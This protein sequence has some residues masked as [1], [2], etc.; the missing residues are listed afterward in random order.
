MTNAPP[1]I[2]R[3]YQPTDFNAVLAVIQAASQADGLPQRHTS[4][5]LRARVRLASSDPRLDPADDMWVASVRAAGVVAYA[6]GSLTGRDGQR[7]YRSECFV[8]PDYR[9]R[10]LGRALL[11]RQ[12]QRALAIARKLA[13]P[14]APVTVTLAAR[15]WEQQA[16]AVSLLE[17][18]GLQRVRTYLQM[19]RDLGQSLADSAPPA[20]LRLEPWLDR[21]ADEAIWQAYD[22]AFSD[23]WG[24]TR[25]SFDS[26]MRRMS[27]GYIQGEHSLVAWAGGAVAGGSLNDL[28]AGP[29]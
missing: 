21:R 22:E 17:S 6:D 1:F 24:Y 18:K 20:G 15:A 25:E 23:H 7:G 14:G 27:L 11:T 16:A 10:G 13:A 8:H 28:D 4:D 5:E 2:I 3:L 26:F 29:T 9:G 12:S 19:T